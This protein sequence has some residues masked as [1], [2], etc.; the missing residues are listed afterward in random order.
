MTPDP[1]ALAKEV[2]DHPELKISPSHDREYQIACALLQAQQ[3]IARGQHTDLRQAQFLHE[4]K[5]ANMKEERDHWWQLAQEQRQEIATLNG[6][7]N[8]HIDIVHG[9]NR[10]ISTLAHQV[11]EIA[12]LKGEIDYTINER[13]RLRQDVEH[14]KYDL[15]EHGSVIEALK[16]RLADTVKALKIVRFPNADLQN[17]RTNG[18]VNHDLEIML[19]INTIIDAAAGPGGEG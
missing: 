6:V 10:Q 2:V 8:D 5:L 7:V 14:L 18:F 12:T 11:E 4:H 3:E 19:K 17:A 1:L 13:D 15:M 16:K 9:V